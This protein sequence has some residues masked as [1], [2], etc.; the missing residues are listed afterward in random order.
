A[1]ATEDCVMKALS[2]YLTV[3]VTAALFAAAAPSAHAAYS[4][5]AAAGANASMH[6]GNTSQAPA[7]VL[8]S[9]TN[10]I[11]P[12]F[13]WNQASV[14]DPSMGLSESAVGTG[15]ASVSPGGLHLS[16]VGSAFVQGQGPDVLDQ[17]GARG[18]GYASGSFNEGMVWNVA[19]LAA[20]T[21]VTMDFQ[22]RVD[23]LTGLTTS[24]LQG[25]NASG[26]RVYDWDLRL[27]NNADHSGVG[28]HSVTN[29]DQP[30]EFRP[31]DFSISVVLGAPM[32]LSLSGSVTASGQAG[33]AC[34]TFWGLVCDAFTHG[35]SANSFADLGH[36]LAW[37]GVT[38]L[39]LGDT[40]V[41]LSSLSVTSDSGFDYTQAYVGTVPEPSSAALLLAGLLL[42]PWL[43][44]RTRL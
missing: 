22:I 10:P 3:P 39:H 33:V 28:F 40:A 7:D 26:Y 44:A 27:Y 11:G 30:D 31:Y 23:G 21:V 29:S 24:V 9:S 2:T 38:G 5:T 36:T 25:G 13:V 6:S 18:T 41:S 35:A 12:L 19:G 16:A 4:A 14:E 20:G 8:G 32:T 1:G 43:R 34:S 37:N 17:G 15:W 42:A